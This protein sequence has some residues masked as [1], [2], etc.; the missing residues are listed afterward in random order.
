MRSTL[1][2]SLIAAGCSTGYT[3]INDAAVPDMAM[4]PAPDLS[5]GNPS[6]CNLVTQDCKVAP[7]TRCTIV[8]GDPMTMTPDIHQCV[9]PGGTN[10]IGQPCT[11]T[12][13]GADDCVAGTVCTLRGVATGSFACRK[14]CHADSDCAQ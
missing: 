10:M 12:D 3:Y 6:D 9:P 7:N 13:F 8:L 11:R 1:L 4:A 5:A 2:L 14:W